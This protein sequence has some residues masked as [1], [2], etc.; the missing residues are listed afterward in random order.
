[1]RKKF[2]LMALFVALSM[3]VLSTPISAETL[4]IG[5]WNIQNLHHEEG[6]SLFSWGTSRTREDY[7]LLTKYRSKFGPGE[8]TEAD[9]IGLQEIGTKAAAERIFPPSRYDLIMSSRHP[10]DNASGA[11]NDIYTAIAVR[12]D[13][14][15]KVIR[16][17]DLLDLV[18]FDEDDNPTRAGTAALLSF[19]D[20][21]FWLMSVHL[22][23]S[24]SAEE[25]PS[26]DS[27]EDC[28]LFWEQMDPL[29]DWIQERTLSGEA[30][31]IVGDFNRRFRQYKFEGE[32]WRAL[33]N[34]NLGEP[35]LSAHPETVTRKCPTRLGRSVEPIDWILMDIRIADWFVDNSFW[36][37][38]FSRADVER[39]KEED[40]RNGLSDHCPISI[41]IVV[42]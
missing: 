27:S 25:N 29:A 18:V 2:R 10:G 16:Q 5:A 9:V 3:M 13:S 26:T 6:V 24:C 32:A 17:E 37:R 30:F 36:E 38:R 7:D 22:K 41:D 4:R 28:K 34:G 42:E 11:K 12:K 31:F 33:N 35:F 8:G 19:R 23:S 39:S 15:V 14:G 20:T 21:N 40:G 1:M